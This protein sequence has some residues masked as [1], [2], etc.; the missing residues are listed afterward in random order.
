VNTWIPLIAAIVGAG[1]VAGFGGSI[2]GGLLQRPKTKAEATK[3]L[4]DAA[5]QLVNEMQEEAIRMR[6]EVVEARTEATDARR[7]TREARAEV[8]ELGRE[9]TEV[10]SAFEELVAYARRVIRS[11]HE[12]GQTLDRLRQ[13][14][15]RELPTQR[16]NGTP[17]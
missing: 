6:S 10:K 11:I 17:L 4:T 9:L 13:T 16:H 8:R 15:P 1:G 7:E 14:V 3:L 5:Q 2:V 12:P